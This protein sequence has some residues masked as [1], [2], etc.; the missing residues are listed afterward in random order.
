M[1]HHWCVSAPIDVNLVR[2]FLAVHETGSFS[3]A[4]S[5]LHVP[6]STVSRAVAALEEA[7]GVRLF[8]R[9]TRRVAPTAAGV[10]LAE[11]ASG[12]LVA[13]D[14]ALTD[15]PGALEARAGTLRLTTTPDLGSSLLA[16]TLARFSARFPSVRVEVHLGPELVD[17]VAGRFDFAIRFARKRFVDSSLVVRKLGPVLFRLYAAPRYLRRRGT[18]ATPADL[19]SHAWVALPGTPRLTGLAP[20]VRHASPRLECDD[21]AF[22]RELLREGA[23]IGMLPSYLAEPDVLDGALERVLPRWSLDTGGIYL[24]HPARREPP[25]RWVTAFRDL[26]LESLREHPLPAA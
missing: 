8:E 22:A 2:A 21:K 18:P 15:L 3:L 13:L 20:F 6:R 7:M 1:V 9:T 4:A 10:V 25:A 12:P 19:S 24:V 11:R 16:G 14:G 26:L 17:L 5:R 23:G